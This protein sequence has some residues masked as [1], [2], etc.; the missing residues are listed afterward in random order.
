MVQR[1]ISCT[2]RVIG[3]TSSWR[4]FKIRLLCGK[5]GYDPGC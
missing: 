1:M 4:V 3:S 5:L 2:D